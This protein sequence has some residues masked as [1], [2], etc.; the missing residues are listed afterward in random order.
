M[1]SFF[2]GIGKMVLMPFYD[3]ILALDYLCKVVHF[4]CI[5]L[6]EI[7]WKL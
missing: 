3:K 2:L 6:L 7:N 1:M 5:N 4:N